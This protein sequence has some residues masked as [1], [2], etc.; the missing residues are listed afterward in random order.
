M[1]V[2]PDVDIDFANRDK[3]LAN[4]WH[5]PATL[6]DAQGNRSLHKTGVYFQDVP[7]NPLEDQCVYSTTQ[8][9]EYGY[10]KFDLLNLNI[11][12]DIR[13]EKHLDDLLSRE[14]VWEL[15]EDR[16]IVD[17]LGHIKGH[18][19]IVDKIKPKSIVDLA[20]C[21]ALIRPGK[22]YLL[23]KDIKTIRDRIWL[24]EEKYYYK[25]SHAIA[26][27]SSIV[28]QLNMLVEDTW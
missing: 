28:V 27:A 6:I 18:F 3:A 7:V 9:S 17:M 24:F 13:D 22:R 26:Y 21:I 14:V 1:G 12:R 2:F 25:K 20:I 10:F 4:T 16:G 23:S 5:V 15:L 8:A 19:D 11:Y